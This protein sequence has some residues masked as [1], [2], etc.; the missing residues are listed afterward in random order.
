MFTLYK[1][2]FFFC[3]GKEIHPSLCAMNTTAGT[4]TKRTQLFTL[5][6][7]KFRVNSQGKFVRDNIWPADRFRC[8]HYASEWH[9]TLSGWKCS[10]SKIGAAERPTSPDIVQ[11]SVFHLWT[12]DLSFAVY[13]PT[14]K[15]FW[16]SEIIHSAFSC[17][18][19]TPPHVCQLLLYHELK[20]LPMV[21]VAHLRPIS[22]LEPPLSW[23]IFGFRSLLIG[24]SGSRSY[25]CIT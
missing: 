14:K 12:K 9:R 1:I 18:G 5:Y 17:L 21:D 11:K 23:T 8:S 22:Y 16:N 19:L 6:R 15:S 24:D 3:A 25:N 13:V 20:L 4:T 10:T 7:N 2:V